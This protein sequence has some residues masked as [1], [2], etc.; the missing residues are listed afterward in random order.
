MEMPRRPVAK[1]SSGASL[2]N[3]RGNRRCG[4]DDIPWR[5]HREKVTRPSLGQFSTEPVARGEGSCKGDYKVVT[6]S[7]EKA[8]QGGHGQQYQLLLKSQGEG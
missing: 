6:E 8:L 4:L 1:G 7:G 3:M 5:E 2:N